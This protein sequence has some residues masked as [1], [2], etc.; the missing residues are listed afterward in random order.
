MN[1]LLNPLS[2]YIPGYGVG[3]RLANTYRLLCG[4]LKLQ[5]LAGCRYTHYFLALP[6]IYFDSFMIESWVYY[7]ACYSVYR[8]YH[9]SCPSHCCVLPILFRVQFC[10]LA[11]RNYIFQVAIDL[12]LRFTSRLVAYDALDSS[13][14]L[15]PL[16]RGGLL[17]PPLLC[18]SRLPFIPLWPSIG[19]DF[20]MTSSVLA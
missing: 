11:N 1:P 5:L 19:S 3:L 8:T 12:G 14:A 6:V 16:L 20:P 2:K 18:I 7:S 13:L 10:W 9:F 4:S 15:R 17:W